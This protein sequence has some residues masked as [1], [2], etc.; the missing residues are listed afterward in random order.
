MHWMTYHCVEVNCLSLGLLKSSDTCFFTHFLVSYKNRYK[1]LE[2]LSSNTM[3]PDKL[4]VQHL[5]AKITLLAE[6]KLRDQ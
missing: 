2:F 5:L 4:L 1:S 6:A 3:C